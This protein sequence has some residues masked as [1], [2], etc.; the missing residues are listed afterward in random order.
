MLCCRYNFLGLCACINGAFSELLDSSSIS[1]ALVKS[2]RSMEFRHLTKLI[3]LVIIPF[4]MHCPHKLLEEWMLKLFLPLF[5]Y[6]EDMLCFSW[7]DLL[8]NGQANVPC[9]LDYLC[10]SEETIN[11][12]EN[13]LLL[14]LTRKF[15]K[16][17][18]SLSSPELNGGLFDVDL[19]PVPDMITACCE[20]KCISSSIIGY[21]RRLIRMFFILFIAYCII[22][23]AFV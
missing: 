2:L 4:A 21:G 14:D 22:R 13:F 23:Y 10:E 18:G 15:S 19:N 11:N 20:L 6:C 3:D 16:L 7:L 5:D 8:N 1:A 9:C 17:L 12:L